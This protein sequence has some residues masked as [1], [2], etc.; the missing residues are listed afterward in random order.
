MLLPLQVTYQNQVY[1]STKGSYRE[2]PAAK[3]LPITT[4]IL[5][6]VISVLG[7]VLLVVVVFAVIYFC[8]RW[9]GKRPGSRKN[10]VAT[11]SEAIELQAS[12]GNLLEVTE[13]AG[14]VYY[15]VTAGGG[16]C[17]GGD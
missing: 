16:G 10:K 9:R 4:I 2:G 8:R 12:S 13:D 17:V 5:I 11:S 15:R 14:I 6:V 3:P 7:L 1:T